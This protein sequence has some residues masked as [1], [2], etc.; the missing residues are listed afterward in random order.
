MTLL[1]LHHAIHN[2]ALAICN[3]SNGRD[4]YMHAKSTTL[5]DHLWNSVPKIE[6][7]EDLWNIDLG[8]GAAGSW[9]AGAEFESCRYLILSSCG[10]SIV[11]AADPRDDGK[12]S[13]RFDNTEAGAGWVGKFGDIMRTV[14]SDTI[15]RGISVGM[16]LTHSSGNHCHPKT[17]PSAFPRGYAG[18]IDPEVFKGPISEGYKLTGLHEAMHIKADVYDPSKLGERHGHCGGDWDECVQTST[19]AKIAHIN[20]NNPHAPHNKAVVRAQP[21]D[22]ANLP[23]D[24]E[25]NVADLTLDDT[26]IRL[27]K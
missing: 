20:R 13:L 16:N 21:I 14:I 3:E 7:C 25:G 15:H 12:I 6:Y 17:D 1:T 8:D 9:I 19:F 24:A 5:F 2:A 26:P 22:G 10:A 27:G 11:I 23:R 4:D 18:E